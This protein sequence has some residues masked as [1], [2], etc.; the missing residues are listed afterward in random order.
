MG[1]KAALFALLTLASA[2][3]AQQPSSSSRDASW[4]DKRVEE[5][6]PS[7][8]ERA[9]DRIAWVADIGEAKRLAKQHGRPIFLFTYDGAKLAGYRC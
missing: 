2:A 5:W 1:P 3:L 7:K 6:Q 8:A 9:F 4:I